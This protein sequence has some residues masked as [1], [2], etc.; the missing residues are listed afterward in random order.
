MPSETPRLARIGPTVDLAKVEFPPAVAH[1]FGALYGTEAPVETAARWVAATR[2]AF[3]DSLDRQP[4]A[5]D[6][7][8]TAD[9]DHVFDPAGPG[10]S[11]AYVCVLDP[12]IYPFLTDTPG[13]VR[14]A[15][16]QGSDQI[17]VDVTP[18]GVAASHPDAVVSVGVSNGADAV[19]TITP[20]V[21]YRQVCG[22]VHVFATVSAYESW[23]A[24]LDAATTSLDLERGIGVARGLADALFA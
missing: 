4:T 18:D 9:G 20:E 2:S 1:G 10:E 5:D 11:Q 21:V 8:T 17:E 19:D 7:C 24:D 3:A 12:L 6:L 16:Q 14:S 22:Y 13:T 15:S 23:A